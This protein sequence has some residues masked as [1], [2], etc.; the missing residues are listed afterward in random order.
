MTG[1]QEVTLLCN[2]LKSQAS[3][4]Y[5]K[6]I[7]NWAPAWLPARQGHEGGKNMPLE[8][9]HFLPFSFLVGVVEVLRHASAQDEW[10]MS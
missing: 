1:N 9:C 5:L 4:S 2:R 7:V 6:W 3:S 10:S 8:A